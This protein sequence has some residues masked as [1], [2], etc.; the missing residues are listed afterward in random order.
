LSGEAGW[1]LGLEVG[2]AAA[3]AHREWFSSRFCRSAAVILGRFFRRE[4]LALG[5][6][7][8]PELISAPFAF[9]LERQN[10]AGLWRGGVL[11]VL[12]S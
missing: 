10:P 4:A 6:K 12:V 7:A 8:D 3:S 9:A 2:S 11:C 5:S 1:G